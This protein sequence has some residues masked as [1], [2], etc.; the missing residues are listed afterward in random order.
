M[1]D[2]KLEKAFGE[3]TCNWC[4]EKD[5]TVLHHA[6]SDTYWH[7][8]CLEAAGDTIHHIIDWLTPKKQSRS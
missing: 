1:S 8:C 4:F 3:S 5:E 6:E 2:M 7:E